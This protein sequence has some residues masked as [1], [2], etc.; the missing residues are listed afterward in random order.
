MTCT[1]SAEGMLSTRNYLRV[2]YHLTVVAPLVR[3]L[4]RNVAGETLMRSDRVPI[5]RVTQHL[6]CS[7]DPCKSSVKIARHLIQIRV[8]VVERPPVKMVASAALCNHLL[9]LLAASDKQLSAV[10]RR[11]NQ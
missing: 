2:F 5:V 6:V 8:V 3:A 10:R 4:I 1:N 9:R 11:K 7:T